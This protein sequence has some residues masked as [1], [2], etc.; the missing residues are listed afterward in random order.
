[1]P[2]FWRATRGRLRACGHTDRAIAV[3]LLV[4][5]VVWLTACGRAKAEDPPARIVISVGPA[6]G[7]FETVGEALAAAYDELP[8][9]DASTRHSLNSRTSA[10]E[11]ERGEVD[12]ALEGARTTYLAYRKGTPDYPAP[13]TKLRALA[14]LFP[15][16][17]HI[18]VH[19]QSGIQTVADM[20][21]RRIFVGPAG[22]STEAAS[23]VVLESHG[24]GFQDIQPVYDRELVIDDFSNL[25]LDGIFYFS[26]V[27]DALAVATMRA[28]DAMLIPIDPE[29]MEPIRSRDRLLKPAF[30]AK[31]AYE[32]QVEAVLTVGSDVLLAARQDLPEG[33]VYVLTKRLFESADRLSGAHPAARYI[34]PDRGPE[35]PIPLHRGATRYYRERELFR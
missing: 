15:T 24:V 29:M 19:R 7:V 23:R 32:G 4:V 35:T 12:L 11:L 8:G 10:D 5:A 18:V 34:D 6:D 1:M 13:H 2:G 21:G 30:I 14:V 27:G 31:G 26:P 16:V 28:D 20:K 25:R 9:I 17:V 33:L 22:S 3:V